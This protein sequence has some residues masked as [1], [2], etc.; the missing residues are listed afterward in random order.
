[1]FSFYVFFFEFP[2]LIRTFAVMKLHLFN[3][4]HDLALAAHVKRF[5]APHVARQ[6]RGDLGF[7]PALWAEDGDIVL[8]DDV[9][10]ALRCVR[11]LK[12]YVSDVLFMTADDLKLMA[13]QDVGLRAL[14]VSP[15]GWDSAVAEQL[16]KLGIEG[17]IPPKEM[18]EQLRQ[19]SSRQWASTHLLPKLL[20]I[21][22]RLCGES[23]YVT[24]LSS[25]SLLHSRP[26]VLKSPWSCSG[27]GIR[28]VM[29][30]VQWKRNESWA[31][32]V[33]GQQGG[34]MVE[35]YYNK[36]KD[37]GMEFEAFADGRVVY[38]GLSLFNTINGAYTGSIVATEQAKTE[39]LEKFVNADLLRLIS[40]T[41][42]ETMADAL[43]GYYTGPFGVDMMVVGLEENGERRGERAFLLHPC[44]ELNLRRTM[45]HVALSL[46]CDATMPQRLM[47]IQYTDRYR[48]QIIP[49][50]ENVLNNSIY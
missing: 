30:E 5:T 35:P 49:T 50:N 10:M 46:P 7:L 4:E 43:Q 42:C 17:M 27:R 38:Q 33:I 22:N 26:C 48:L 23:Y 11:H 21:D 20:Q 31:R 19:I 39:L 44:V 3:P 12:K 45:G 1:M 29:N 14:M 2:S 34:I 24:D 13:K 8:V 36:V 25:C 16:M 47:T 15:W 37:F 18:L 28:Y 6:L 40:E 9:D 41:I 32:K